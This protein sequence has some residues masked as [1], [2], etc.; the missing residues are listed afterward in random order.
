[1]VHGRANVETLDPMAVPRA[2]C[3]PFSM[4]NDAA[5]GGSHWHGIVVE[6]AI[7]EFPS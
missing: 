1:M 3:G 2:T 7:E 5:A 6:G 4:G